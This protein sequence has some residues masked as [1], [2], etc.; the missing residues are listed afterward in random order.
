MDNN[1]EKKS[2][3]TQSTTREDVKQGSCLYGNV[4]LEC[5]KNTTICDLFDE[6]VK[7]T[8][9]N[10][11]VISGDTSLTYR[12]LDDRANCIAA[13]L[14]AEGV[15]ADSIVGVLVERS[16]DMVVGILGVLKAGAAYLP[17]DSEYPQARLAYIIDDSK[18][19][20]LLTQKSLTTRV[21]FTGHIVYME[22]E[23]LYKKDGGKIRGH[24]APDS[25]AYVIYTSGSTGNPKGV[26]V[27]H[28][29]VVNFFRGIT[30]RIDFSPGEKILALTSMSFDISVLEILLPLVSGLT[31]VIANKFQCRN[32]KRIGELIAENDIDILQ[33]TP[34][35]LQLI[36][37]F[38]QDLSC[39]K[40][41]KKILIGGEPCPKMLLDKIKS[42]CSGRI[43][44]MYG[45]TETTIWSTVGE[46]T[47]SDAVHIGT[48]VLNTG[49]YIV[50]ENL[51]IQPLGVEGEMCISG[52]GV[53]RGYL[54]MPS[55]TEDK[56]VAS[57][58]APGERM[59]KT[60]DIACIMPD[61]NIEY[62]GRTDQQIKIRGYR[63]EPAEIESNLLAYEKI[64][65]AVVQPVNTDNGDIQLCAYIVAKDEL[66]PSE[67][68]SYLSARLPDYM[69]P[70]F[71]M[72]ISEIPL[73]ASGKIDKQ[74]LPTPV[75]PPRDIPAV[76]TDV[77]PE[78]A[79]SVNVKS[80]IIAILQKN[81]SL[82]VPLESIH[83]DNLLADIGLN[84]I[85]FI[86]VVVEI[87]NKY[88]IEFL[89]EDLDSNRFFTVGSIINYVIEKAAGV[90]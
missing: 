6:Q 77:R 8:P 79:G 54:N 53:A 25:L 11:A 22:N 90:N 52:C 20:I 26:L 24:I 34:S 44:N 73:T 75:L 21:K 68:K 32:P 61:G 4:D 80:E 67:L 5:L 89:D 86:K 17:L 74:A 29:S 9:E 47:G 23:D 36:G 46:L 69:I 38:D 81:V 1:D 72:M 30:G 88:Q 76:G 14:E 55:L 35:R 39:L 87:E 78:T 83:E 65:G 3:G 64:N 48:P 82:I 70:V 28:R 43:Y 51:N 40:I 49:I 33:I 31:I 19:N 63:V 12:E 18:I 66:S 57:P 7:K 50:D 59:Y 85:S 27:E 16:I 56:F 37:N 10:T 2:V 60:G 15:K 58:F 71:Y 62:I 42:T 13:A 45:P 41:L 84:S